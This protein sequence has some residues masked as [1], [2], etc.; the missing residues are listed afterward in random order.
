MSVT[1][2]DHASPDFVFSQVPESSVNKNFC[3]VHRRVHVKI[4]AW[5]RSIMVSEREYKPP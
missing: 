5:A 3:S 4:F 2:Y 1:I